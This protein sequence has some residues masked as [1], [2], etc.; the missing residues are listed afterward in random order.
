M[1]RPS[2][3]S[4]CFT[5]CVVLSVWAEDSYLALYLGVAMLGL[6]MAS[7]IATGFLWTEQRITVSSKVRRE[8]ILL[9]EY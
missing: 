9:L 3:V 5:G 2:S 4:V 6:G 1:R 8:N 7:I